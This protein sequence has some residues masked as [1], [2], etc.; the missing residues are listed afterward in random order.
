MG[1]ESHP[2]VS[3]LP[4]FLSHLM[5]AAE[6][7]SGDIQAVVAFKQALLDGLNVVSVQCRELYFGTVWA[8]GGR[9]STE[10]TPKTEY[11]GSFLLLFWL[12]QKVA[13][14][15]A[16]FG[17]PTSNGL[18]AFAFLCD[19]RYVQLAMYRVKSDTT[20]QLE[21]TKTFAV[22]I[23]SA[24]VAQQLSWNGTYR[25]RQAARLD[26][27]CTSLPGCHSQEWYA[28]AS[29]FTK[30]TTTEGPSFVFCHAVLI[31]LA[32]YEAEF[33]RP[34]ESAAASAVPKARTIDPN[35][36]RSED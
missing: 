14:T 26:G 29:G 31:V 32:E 35:M 25:R 17:S 12:K 15:I 36:T 27:C 30:A 1:V 16:E 22:V 5:A 4:S 3:M 2:T 21:R 20:I 28:A 11:K 34:M 6:R 9:S 19:I 33:P 23:L 24:S 8:L 13:A 10:L 18:M 7:Q